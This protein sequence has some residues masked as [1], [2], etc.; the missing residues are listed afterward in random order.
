MSNV[1]DFKG[2]LLRRA[3]S[4]AESEHFVLTRRQ[5]RLIADR[6]PLESL[7]ETARN[8]RLRAQREATWC[9]AEVA[10]RY[11][12]AKIAYDEACTCAAKHR[13]IPS[14]GLSESDDHMFNVRN[15]R[16]AQA[17][18]MLT[19]A[20]TAAAIAW[21]RQALASGQYRYT[22]V[23]REDIERAIELD[24]AWLK[25]HPTRRPKPA[26]ESEMAP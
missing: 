9:A 13:I 19:P 5:E 21:K 14:P 2:A 24:A 6:R 10:T 12:K 18:Q 7:T 3:C 16:R 22:D 25:A 26:R 23:K 20:P 4:P 15:W 17:E 8:S 11:W 1:I